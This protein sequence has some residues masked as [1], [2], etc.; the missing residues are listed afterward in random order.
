MIIIKMNGKRNSLKMNIVSL[1]LIKI[2]KF[3]T[4][5]RILGIILIVIPI[6]FFFL[7]QNKMLAFWASWFLICAFLFIIQYYF[8]KRYI[9]IGRITMDSDK[10]ELLEHKGNSMCFF[11]EDKIKVYINYKGHKG[12]KGHKGDYNEL[13][14]PLFT[15]EGIGTMTIQKGNELQIPLFTKEGIGTMTIQK[16]NAISKIKFLAVE[17]CGLKLKYF[18]KQFEKNGSLVGF[19]WD[20][21]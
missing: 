11:S 17:D 12:H 10:I 14:I 1:F 20:K 19:V 3:I 16:G 6:P 4:G 8:L 7:N 9:I 13:Q 15:K 21:G 2:N 5:L 18:A